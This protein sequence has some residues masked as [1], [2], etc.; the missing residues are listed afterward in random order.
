MGAKLA[1]AKYLLCFI[2]ATILFGCAGIVASALPLTSSQTCLMRL[3]VGALA[4]GA[5]F[6]ATGQKMPRPVPVRE[7]L[8]VA[9]SG[10]CL[11]L[12]MTMLFEA[13]R[14]LGVGLGAILA[15][16]APIITIALSPVLFHER[17]RAV[18]IAGFA[19]VVTGIVLLNLSALAGSVSPVGIALGLGAAAATAGMVVLNKLAPRISGIPCTTIQLTAALGV[20]TATALF[21]D[22]FAFIA[23]I[24]AASW[25]LIVAFGGVFTALAYFLYYRAID[26]L[27]L[28]TVSVC[29]YVEPLTAVL[30]G[31]ALLGEVMTPLQIL[32]ALC[33]VG[34]ALVGEM[35]FKLPAAQRRRA[36]RAYVRLVRA[37]RRHSMRPAA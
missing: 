28:Q 11:G 29:A 36:R 26:Q 37:R 5:I 25:P 14:L 32:G 10:V 33:V 16:C 30:A 20:A 22:G 3:L 8:F 13:Y 17:L 18:A 27:P 21:G 2:A 34:G 7:Y 12:C 4:M 1:S 9:L 24:P 23:A 31:A 6:L 15:A 35:H 19:V